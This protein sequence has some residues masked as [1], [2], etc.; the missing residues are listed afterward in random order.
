MAFLGGEAVNDGS[1][2]G[3]TA[4][5]RTGRWQCPTKGRFGFVTAHGKVSG[6]FGPSKLSGTIDPNGKAMVTANLGDLVV[7]G[8]GWLTVTSATF[9][10]TGADAGSPTH[11]M[12]PSPATNSA[13]I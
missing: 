5:E 11:G 7:D 8:P 3:E 10:S 12:G 6:K 4:A 2:I 13:W 9:A 1:W